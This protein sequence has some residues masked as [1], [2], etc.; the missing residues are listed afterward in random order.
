MFPTADELKIVLPLN[1]KLKFAVLNVP[2]ET[3]KLPPELLVSASP[4]VTVMPEPLIVIGHKNVLPA[5][6]I[7]P[8]PA[9]VKPPL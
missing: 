1:V 5:E 6:V 3:R 7:V 8:V 4:S 9:N 2:V